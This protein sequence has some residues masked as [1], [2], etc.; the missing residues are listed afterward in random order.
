MPKAD[1]CASAKHF[2]I[3]CD[4]VGECNCHH[5]CRSAI[6]YSCQPC[7]GK[8]V[9]RCAF[10]RLSVPQMRT[11]ILEIALLLHLSAQRSAAKLLSRDAA[12]RINHYVALSTPLILNRADF[13]TGKIVSVVSATGEGGVQWATS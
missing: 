12:R 8:F 4:L 11:S 3:P 7:A 6:H 1:S 10:K 5:L 13:W 9:E 2:V